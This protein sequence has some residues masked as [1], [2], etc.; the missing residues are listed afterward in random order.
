MTRWVPAAELEEATT[1][2]GNE[3]SGALEKLDDLVSGLQRT[4]LADAED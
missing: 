3:L 1:E 2:D 4:L